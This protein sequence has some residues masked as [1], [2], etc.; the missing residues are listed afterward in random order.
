MADPREAGINSN[1]TFAEVISTIVELA[2]VTIRRTFF[3]T[4]PSTMKSFS[5]LLVLVACVAMVAC[6]PVQGKFVESR[7]RMAVESWNL[8]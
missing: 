5:C 3:P 2:L 8:R 6:A 1:R 4:P 7:S